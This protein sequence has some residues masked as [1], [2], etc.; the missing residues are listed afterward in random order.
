MNG[1]RNGVSLAVLLL[2]SDGEG[3]L[4]GKT[5]KEAHAWLWGMELFLWCMQ[6]S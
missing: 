2:C 5:Q 6:D 1:H 3:F 4:F